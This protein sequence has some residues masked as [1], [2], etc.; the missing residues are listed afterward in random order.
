MLVDN[1]HNCFVD[2][3]DALFVVCQLHILVIFAIDFIDEQLVAPHHIDRIHDEAAVN[4]AD[5]LE[6]VANDSVHFAHGEMK[7]KL[8]RDEVELFQNNFLFIDGLN[9]FFEGF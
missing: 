6:S 3:D 1:P 4:F 9:N 7:L 2:S 5:A 8:L